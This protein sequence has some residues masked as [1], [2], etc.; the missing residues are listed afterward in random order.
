[1]N[2]LEQYLH[3]DLQRMLDR[4][5]I[6]AHGDIAPAVSQLVECLAGIIAHHVWADA[7]GAG[8][9]ENRHSLEDLL[10]EINVGMQIVTTGEFQRLRNE[11]DGVVTGKVL[12]FR[13]P[14]SRRGG[15]R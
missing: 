13:R 7:H 14:T 15:R 9:P 12:P 4:S 5:L 6:E 11:T 8:C 10:G 1:M 3:D 2:K